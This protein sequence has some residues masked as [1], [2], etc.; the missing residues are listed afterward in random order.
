MFFSFTVSTVSPAR[1][2]AG[3]HGARARAE[4][5]NRGGKVVFQGNRTPHLGCGFSVEDSGQASDYRSLGRCGAVAEELQVQRG[6]F[7]TGE[8]CDRRLLDQREAGRKDSTRLVGGGRTRVRG[9]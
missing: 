4:N 6:L 3:I 5:G 9:R 2:D 1:V 7:P 8:G